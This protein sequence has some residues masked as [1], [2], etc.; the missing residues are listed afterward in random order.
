MQVTIRYKEMQMQRRSDR[1]LQQALV[2]RHRASF[3]EGVVNL[4]S[5][6]WHRPAPV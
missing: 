5:M 1:S 2:R 6:A 3:D 4:H